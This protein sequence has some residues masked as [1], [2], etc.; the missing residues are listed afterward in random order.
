MNTALSLPSTF[1]IRTKKKE[2]VCV[3]SSRPL[4]I[5]FICWTYGFESELGR[6][7]ASSD[8]AKCGKEVTGDV[9]GVCCE[10]CEGWFHQFCV[11]MSRENSR[12]LEH[13]LK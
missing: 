10:R 6:R 5:L 9:P 8:C 4:R 12:H 11:E 3:C 13:A 1:K 2:N 7:M